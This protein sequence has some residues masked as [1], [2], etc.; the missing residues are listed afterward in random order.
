[1]YLNYRLVLILV[2]LTRICKNLDSLGL[3]V[4]HIEVEDIWVLW[5]LHFLKLIINLV[6]VYFLSW[7][8]LTKCGN[9]INYL[10]FIFFNHL[11]FNI[12]VHLLIFN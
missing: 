9:L 4:L 1:M 3:H 10:V 8:E 12:L 5:L 11:F 6:N 2:Y 7:I